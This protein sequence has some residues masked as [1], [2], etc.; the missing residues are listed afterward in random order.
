MSAGGRLLYA[1]ACALLLL[2]VV[3]GF[4]MLWRVERAVGVA[5]RGV[6]A[7]AFVVAC[8][9]TLCLIFSLEA[10]ARASP[11]YD[12]MGIN[13]GMRFMWPEFFLPENSLGYKDREPGPKRGPRI[14]V[15]GDSFTEGAGVRRPDRFSSVL[16]R[17]YRETTDPEL[18][19]YNAW[20]LRDGYA[21]RGPDPLGD[22]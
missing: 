10:L 21:G 11:I 6:A 13:P 19:V 22:R 1:A 5:R 9:A 8:G 16:E 2:N 7:L 20:S 14:L 15:L 18:E 3:F 4:F 17:L 12:S